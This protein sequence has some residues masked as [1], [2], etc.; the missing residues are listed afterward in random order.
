MHKINQLESLKIL[1]AVVECGN[2]S[3]AAQRL[4]VTPAWVSKSI[5]RLETY[6]G[7]CLFKRST[8]CL[9]ITPDGEHCYQQGLLLLERWESLEANM[10]FCCKKPKGKLSI[11]AP[12]SWG[13]YKLKEILVDFINLYPDIQLDIK[14][15]DQH[16]NVL[17][18][19][20]DLV[21]RLTPQL[22]DSSLLCRK[23]TSYPFIACATSSYLQKNGKPQ[24]PDDLKQHSCLVYSL[25]DKVTQWKFFTHDSTVSIYPNIYL[26]SNNSMVLHAAL[27]A[28]KGIA[29]IPEFIVEDELKSGQLERV[30]PDYQTA[31]LNLF[32]L[33][34]GNREMSYPLQILHDFLYNYFN[35]MDDNKTLSLPKAG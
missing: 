18:E 8:R 30:L 35:P 27:T 15:N 21:L 4:K 14:L 34:H 32:F 11:N 33:R 13:I 10:S 24:H 12:V 9:T 7:T 1:K 5:E 25:P 20:Y 28:D 17:E 3:S 19:G 23:L 29:M 31:T 6:L 2:F 16:I 22:A 26:E